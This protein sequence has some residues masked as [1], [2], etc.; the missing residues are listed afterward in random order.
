MDQPKFNVNSAKWNKCCPDG[1]TLTTK[2]TCEKHNI[3]FAFRPPLINATFFR[4]CI[5][6]SEVINYQMEAV[7]Y[8]LSNKSLVYE[9]IQGDHLYILQNGSLLVVYA[10][11]LDG[12]DIHSEY[13]LDIDP[14]TQ[15]LFALVYTNGS[16]LEL[17][18]GFYMSKFYQG[19]ACIMIVSFCC[20]IVT[21]F[22]YVI[23]PRFGTLHG[24]SF[25]LHS[26]NLAMGYIITSSLYMQWDG[27]SKMG[28]NVY[29]QYFVSAAFMWQL[30]MCIDT[31]INVWYY[32]PRKISPIEG[33]FRGWI[34]FALYVIF[35]QSIPFFFIIHHG[36]DS[37]DINYYM[38]TL[39]EENH[40]D[41]WYY[42]G[43]ILTIIVLCIGMFVAIYYGFRKL[44]EIQSFA[45]IIRMTL[46]KQKKEEIALPYCSKEMEYV[47]DS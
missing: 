29:I 31:I 8:L 27:I 34:H 10:T 6:D 42:Y 24:R 3:T 17:K 1:E 9:E 16:E 12:Y 4:D 36:E 28:G 30:T 33:K 18:S 45:Y 14:S 20:L 19:I 2:R 13:C 32:I 47:K 7:P 41:Q 26:L 15:T 5:E 37:A 46:R 22:F 35:S 39:G 21:A 43:P 11:M 40:D 23:V 25:A 38:S 44:N